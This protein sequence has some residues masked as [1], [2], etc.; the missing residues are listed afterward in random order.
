M[1]IGNGILSVILLVLFVSLVGNFIQYTY[2]RKEPVFETV[3]EIDTLVELD[4]IFIPDAGDIFLPNPEPIFF[5]SVTNIVTHRD[6]FLHQYG[7]IS[8]TEKVRGELLSKR[9]QFKF[10]VP[11][12]YKT[13]TVTKNVTRTIRNDLF[14]VNGG[15]ITDFSGNISPAIGGTYIWNNHRNI[16][17]LDIGLNRQISVSAGFV[18][19]R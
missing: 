2:F 5:D 3:I 4:T 16:L 17:S 6:T 14:F 1:K 11:E 12:Y 13:R 18:L 7:W 15:I 19:W 9:I 10:D 8:T